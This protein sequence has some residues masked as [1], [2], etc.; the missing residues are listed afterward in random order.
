MAQDSG[1]AHIG[2]LVGARLREARQAKNMTQSQLAQDDFSVSYISAIERGQI[3]PSLRAMEIFAQ[4]LGLS[5]K[6]LLL[7]PPRPT[8]PVG[9]TTMKET[10]QV[11]FQLLEAEALLYQEAIEQA[12]PVLQELAS[13]R[14]LPPSQKSM[15][16]YLLGKAHL[17][18]NDL[19]ASE[20]FLAEAAR[21][22]KETDSLL[23][24]RILTAQGIVHTLMNHHGQGMALFQLCREKLE[25]HPNLDTSLTAEIY[26]YL[27]QHYLEL[28]RDED[29]LAL[30]QNALQQTRA[31]EPEQQIESYTQALQEAIQVEEIW[32]AT[33][34]AHKILHLL[35]IG[36]SQK[37]YRELYHQLGRAL[38]EGDSEQARERLEETLRQSTDTLVQASAHVH[39]ATW[40]LAH[41]KV[42]EAKKHAQKAR[43]LLDSAGT[44]MI[45]ADTAIVSGKIEYAQK[46]YQ[47]GDT[48]FEQGLSM[49]EQLGAR[50]EL[51]DHSAEYAQ[52]L[53]DRGD[54][55]R[56]VAYWKKAFEWRQRSRR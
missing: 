25:G 18:L 32:H 56:A 51:A 1:Q 11:D 48:F 19:Q 37:L 3:H 38:L 46:R 21:Q 2:K 55:P 49:L 22:M 41:H 47:E 10:D 50:E 26:T 34:T 27:G 39:L 24:I 31:S 12:I 5:S 8:G 14:S 7:S 29:A 52:L 36:Q 28:N 17:Q 43:D 9:L 54:M 15:A 30:F 23:A 35:D 16:L 20:H 45:A 53:E 6:D 13:K 33:L 40:Q 4:R 44:S 42:A